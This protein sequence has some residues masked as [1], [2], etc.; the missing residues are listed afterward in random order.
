MS[1]GK[2]VPRKDA[3]IKANGDTQYS[4]DIHY[5]NELQLTIIRSTHPHAKIKNIHIDWDQ[6]NKLNAT[7]GT[8]KDIPGKNVIRIV[9]DDQPLLAEKTV[10]YIGQPIVIVI[11]KTQKKAKKAASSIRIC[12]LYT[13]PSPRD[14][15]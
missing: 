3:W 9:F 15:S 2:T 5:P 7:V 4:Y 12:L 14:R 1:V 6:I 10:K 13:S 11:A 8:Y